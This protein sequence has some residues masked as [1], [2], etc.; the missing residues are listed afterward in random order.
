MIGS[1]RAASP[2]GGACKEGAL[3]NSMPE[4]ALAAG[5][6]EETEDVACAAAPSAEAASTAMERM[7][8]RK[9]WQRRSRIDL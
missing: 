4:A 9:A 3:R 6:G 5:A 1:W 7:R 2:C 8:S